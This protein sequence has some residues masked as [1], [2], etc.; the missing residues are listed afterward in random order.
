MRDESKVIQKTSYT[1]EAMVELLVG[2]PL[3]SQR[4]LA[5]HFGY[6]EGWISRIM[7]SDAFREQVARRKDELIDPVV[8]Q[9]IEDR[10]AALVDLSTNVLMENLEAKRSTDAALKALEISA[11]ALGY[12]VSKGAS[13]QVNQQFVV[14]MP[15]KEENS[16]KWV[17]SHKPVV[18]IDGA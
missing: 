4:E 5:Q 1:H 14:A 7:R 6:T 12:G 13:V 18:V 10:L 3:I 11:R 8:L 16:T 15:A 17:E 9:T 2:N